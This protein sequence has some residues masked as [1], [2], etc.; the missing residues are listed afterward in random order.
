[1]LPYWDYLEATRNSL[2]LEI[3]RVESQL[4]LIDMVHRLSGSAST[5]PVTDGLIL[6]DRQSGQEQR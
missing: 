6:L 4:D 3:Q 5:L 2:L 1:M